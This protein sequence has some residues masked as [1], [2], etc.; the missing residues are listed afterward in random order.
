MSQFIESVVAVIRARANSVGD[1][2]SF[3]SIHLAAHV[4]AIC[5]YLYEAHSDARMDLKSF[6][7]EDFAG[8][9]SLQ[10]IQPSD[11]V[12][13]YWTL[14]KALVALDSQWADRSKKADGMALPVSTTLDEIK[15]DN[16]PA[17][18]GDVLHWLRPVPRWP[19]IRQV[20]CEEMPHV[21]AYPPR[22]GDQLM[23]LGML[24]NRGG[25]MPQ[26]EHVIHHGKSRLVSN[27]KPWK[28]AL[29][30]MG[31]G[32]GPLFKVDDRG[33]RFTVDRV[34]AI[35]GRT[36]QQEHLTN[37]A[38]DV[39]THNINV[40]VLPELCV[41]EVAR[42]QI[43]DLI[44]KSETLSAV[45]A[46]SFHFWR[47]ESSPF[48]E[49]TVA[50]RA[51]RIWTH[52]KRGFFRVTDV[53]VK[54]AKALFPLPLPPLESK[55]LEGIQRGN[56]VGFLDTRVGRIAVLVCADLI[57]PDGFN[58]VVQKAR[59]DFLFVVSMSMKSK[60]FHDAA[61]ELEKHGISTCYVNARCVCEP[62]ESL[63][64]VNLALPMLNEGP[65]TRIRW[66]LKLGIESYSFANGIWSPLVTSSAALLLP[67]ERGLVVDLAAHDDASVE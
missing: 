51:G 23:N 17:V 29:C 11:V 64:F 36:E 41:D 21:N 67:D 37:L 13:L 10:S 62:A 58:D 28:I 42:S 45:V 22:P 19:R 20:R 24:W 26:P 57:A 7:T 32:F 35:C 39:A 48:N 16:R 65:P 1:D 52:K 50:G 53:Q 40:L 44:R 14:L 46:G 49:A 33:S 25:P 54:K 30:P 34:N 61:V 8:I 5:T 38:A 12:G 6:P 63:A 3:E 56:Y 66:S 18:K 59:P 15:D 60:G 2:K 55:I 4:F 31:Q 43:Y 9:Q 27:H 47:D